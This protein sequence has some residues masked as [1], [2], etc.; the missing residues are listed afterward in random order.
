MAAWPE[1][2][3]WQSCRGDS[4][5]LDAMRV[6]ICAVCRRATSPSGVRQTLRFAFFLKRHGISGE[7]AHAVCVAGLVKKHHREI[8]L[9]RPIEINEAE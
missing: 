5:R 7:R 1:L 4:A 2:T 6:R 9:L 3:R 8:K